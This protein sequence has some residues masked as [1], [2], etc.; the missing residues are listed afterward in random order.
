MKNLKLILVATLMAVFAV[1]G[2]CAQ[3]KPQGL[4]LPTN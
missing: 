4:T 2:V 3:E 1:F